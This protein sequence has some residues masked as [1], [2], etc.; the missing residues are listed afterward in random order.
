MSGGGKK[1]TTSQRIFNRMM[2]AQSTVYDIDELVKDLVQVRR[3]VPNR[4]DQTGIRDAVD[5]LDIASSKVVLAI[6]K[7]EAVSDASEARLPK[8]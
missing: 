1:L 4:E 3:R 2:W 5:L 8:K 6:K 7:L